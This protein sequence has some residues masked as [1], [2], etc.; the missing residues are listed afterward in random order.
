MHVW[1]QCSSLFKH[2]L[3]MDDMK[4]REYTMMV[5]HLILSGNQF[6]KA[7]VDTAASELIIGCLSVATQTESENGL[8]VVEDILMLV[9]CF[10]QIFSKIP[11]AEKLLTLEIC[12]NSLKRLPEDETVTEACDMGVKYSVPDVSNVQYIAADFVSQCHHIPNLASTNGE[13]ESKMLCIVKELECLGLASSHH[14]H[15]NILQE[16][17]QLLRTS[18][19]LLQN[20]E[21]I[22]HQG[23]NVFSNI[24][25]VTRQ[26]EV[27]TDHPVF[28]LKRDLIRLIGNLV[29]QNTANQDLVRELDGIPLILN[30]T[31]IDANNPFISQWSIFA[32]HN[33]TEGNEKNISYIA[34]LKMEGIANNQALLDELGISAEVQGD[35]VFVKKQRTE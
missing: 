17:D 25:K 13:N 11:D 10:Q 2:M 26:A 6:G 24:D 18:I 7:R 21:E 35:K 19:H 12:I 27:N 1:Q 34:A 30:K 14:R 23:Q 20:L 33:L 29:Y 32:A 31:T 3:A 5:V 28:G 9:D 8:L 22:G 16:N 4:L 15:Y